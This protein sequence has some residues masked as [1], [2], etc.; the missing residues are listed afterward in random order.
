MHSTTTKLLLAAVLTVPAAATAAPIAIDSIET[1]PTT[2]PDAGLVLTGFTA[3]GVDYVNLTQPVSTDASGEYFFRDGSVEPLTD[4]AAVLDNRLD[5]G[6][7]NQG[8]FTVQFGRSPVA[9]E[10]FYVF[11][12]D[13]ARFDGAAFNLINATGVNVGDFT[14]TIPDTS[15]SSLTNFPTGT[16][17]REVGTSNLSNFSVSGFTFTIDDFTGTTGDLST[18]T[19]LRFNDTSA[20]SQ[21]FDIA[22]IGLA[23]VVPEPGSAVALAA[24][25]GLLASRRRR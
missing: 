24:G 2:T 25:L 19:G 4:A 21:T 10:S 6:L 11:D 13:A 8:E 23:T 17:D 12:L 20:N 9:G 22:A 5:T 14:L 16:L 15:F 3:D 7:L 1:L 18:V